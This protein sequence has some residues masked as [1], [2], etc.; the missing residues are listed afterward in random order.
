[1][2]TILEPIYL[3]GQYLTE[4]LFAPLVLENNSH[5]TWREFRILIDFYRRKGHHGQRTGVFSPKFGLKTKVPASD[6]IGFCD[7]N[8]NADVCLINPFP[9]I[10]YYSFNIWM[11][12]EIAHPG[13]T[14]VAQDL[15]RASGIDW[16]LSAVPRH[17][18]SNLCYSNF[19]VGTEQFWEAYVGGVLGRIAAFLERDPDNAVAKRV[20]HGT[21]HTDE[22]PFLPFIVERLLSTYLSLSPALKV[23]AYDTGDA[24]QYCLTDVERDVVA[25]MS[26]MVDVADTTDEF[27]DEL[28]RQ[29]FLMSSICHRYGIAYFSAN[30]HPHS[31][32]RVPES[33]LEC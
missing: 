25:Y 20:M 15:L 24:L 10:S 13:L 11:Q 22:A 14:G 21:Q 3:E 18:A 19:W 1:M 31:G 8:S 6:F 23:A 28:K 33:I 7:D 32:K 16:D 30:A 12:G 17:N 5:A 27:S 2:T 29:M 9:Q 26:A 4:P